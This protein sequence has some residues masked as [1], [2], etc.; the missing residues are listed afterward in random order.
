MY[1]TLNVCPNA[2]PKTG[3]EKRMK[4]SKRN[5]DT[6]YAL[7]QSRNLTFATYHFAMLHSIIERAAM[8]CLCMQRLNSGRGWGSSWVL[9]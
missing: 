3:S 6:A 4:V 5:F 1:F 8:F 2:T 9:V 7:L